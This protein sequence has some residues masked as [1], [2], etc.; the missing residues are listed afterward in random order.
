MSSEQNWCHL[1]LTLLLTEPHLAFSAGLIYWFITNHPSCPVTGPLKGGLGSLQGPPL[2]W[3]TEP[4]SP[5][6]PPFLTNGHHQLFRLTRQ[7]KSR[8]MEV[9]HRRGRPSGGAPGGACGGAPLGRGGQVKHRAVIHAPRDGVQV[10]HLRQRKHVTSY[11]FN[12]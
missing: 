12:S 4:P 1:S 8:L 7:A 11:S 3:S 10:C 9:P 2:A 6:S 5:F